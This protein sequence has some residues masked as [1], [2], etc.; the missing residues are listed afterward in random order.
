M[1]REFKLDH[2]SKTSIVKV[3]EPF[4]H[5]VLHRMKLLDFLQPQ[6]Q[7]SPPPQSST[8]AHSSS[9]QPPFTKPPS[10]QLSPSFSDAFYNSLSAK[11]LSLQ[12]QQTSM[13][14]SK[15]ELLNNQFLLMEHFMNMRLKMDSFE[16]TQLEILDH[17]KTHFLPPLPPES[18]I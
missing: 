9:T 6:H 17:L 1:F 13:M 18:N 7:P 11:I 15:F 8:H 4:D 12:T 5:A 3:F 2:A 16:A 14:A 10:T